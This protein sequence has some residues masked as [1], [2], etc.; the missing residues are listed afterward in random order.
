MKQFEL[1]WASLPEPVSIFVRGAEHQLDGVALDE[2]AASAT[3]GLESRSGDTVNVA[4]A[5]ERD[6]TEHGHVLRGEYPL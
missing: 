2:L 5:P 3:G 4:Q 6:L 1:W